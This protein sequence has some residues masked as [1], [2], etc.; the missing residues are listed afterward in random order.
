MAVL[1]EAC[2]KNGSGARTR[3]EAGFSI[4]QIVVTLAVVG[5][6]SSFAVVRINAARDQIRLTNAAREFANYAEKARIDSI[7][8]HVVGGAASLT[9]NSTTTYQVFMDFDYNGTPTTR[10]FTLP[11]GVTFNGAQVTQ[12]D[13]TVTN[14]TAPPVTFSFDWRGRTSAAD[15]ITFQNTRQQSST[16]GVTTAGEISLDRASLTLGTSS[17]TAA[18]PDTV[19]LL[20]GGSTSATPAPTATPTTTPTPQPTPT[21]SRACS[22]GEKPATTRCTCYSPMSLNGSGKCM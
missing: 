19:P 10:T 7:R 22:R 18:T 16:V 2:L 11:T 21:P 14:V 1:K 17:Y 4:L 8:R 3:G 5:I 13:G 20:G 12:T 9:V 15:Q 6:V